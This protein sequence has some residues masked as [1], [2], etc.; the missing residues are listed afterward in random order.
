MTE[1]TDIELRRMGDSADLSDDE[2]ARLIRIAKDLA[3]SQMFKGADPRT[4]ITAHEAFAKILIG[5]DLGI[6]PTQ[7]LMSVD[8]VRG[9][10]QMRAVLLAGF[11]RQ[12]PDYD[13]E[14]LE[15][16]DTHCKIKFIRG[17]QIIGLSEFS[18]ADA[19]KAGLTKPTRNGEPSMYDKHPRNMY[20]ARAMSNGVRWYCP[21]LT[22]GVPVYTEADALEDVAREVTAGDGDGQPVGWQGISV[23]RTALLE[24]ILKRAEARGH[25][26]LAN[27]AAVEMIVN[28]QTDDFIDRW[29]DTANDELSRM[30]VTPERAQEVADVILDAAEVMR[31]VP[32]DDTG[33]LTDREALESRRHELLDAIVHYEAEPDDTFD[34][35]DLRAELA[36]LE[37]LLGPAP[38]PG[39]E[40]M[41]L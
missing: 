32:E 10:I 23:G 15:H 25:A 20:W 31:D 1:H 28:G 29:I 30:K 19:D 7:A 38:I 36:D 4:P 37:S 24:D 8:M 33:A 26:G 22:G 17:D 12:S 40:E 41:D 35:E 21:D 27:R 6:S 13:Y 14:V 3:A 2:L 39:Q 34:V 16:D 5:R 11:V 18:R 9:N